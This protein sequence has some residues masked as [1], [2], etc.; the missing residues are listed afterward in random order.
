MSNLE[1]IHGITLQEWAQM[2]KLMVS[3]VEEAK[4][5]QAMGIDGAVWDEVN[6]LWTQRLAE[7]STFQI[8]QIYA[9]AFG[10]EVTEPRLKNLSA[11]IS[12]EGAQ[13]LERIKNDRY[14]YHELNGARNAAYAY[15]LDG[16]Q[17]ILDNY[18]VSLGDF[19][20]VAMQYMALRNSAGGDEDLIH[21]LDYEKQKQEE[22]EERFANERGGNVADDIEF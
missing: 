19:Q 12:P 1:P 22:Y 16:A 13:N 7:D 9:Q 18:G 8:G 3:G 5:I 6:A 11:N 15:G 17:W 10:T 20:S 2:A 21:F 14:F 4:V